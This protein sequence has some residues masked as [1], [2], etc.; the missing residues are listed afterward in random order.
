MKHLFRIVGS[1]IFFVTTGITVSGGETEID[2][3]DIGKRGE[4]LHQA[5]V[6]WDRLFDKWGGSDWGFSVQQTD[7]GGY[8]VAARAYNPSD[9]KYYAWSIKTDENG[10]NGWNRTYGGETNECWI[11]G[12]Q[13]NDGGYIVVS[14]KYTG[15]LKR[16][17]VWLLKLNSSGYLE[18]ERTYH[19]GGR[20]TGMS[21][22]QTNDNG[23]IITGT[24][25]TLASASCLLIKTNSSGIEEWHKTLNYG[26]FSMGQ[27]VRQTSDGRYIVVANYVP[28]LEDPSLNIV[29]FKTLSNG[30]EQWH[31]TFGGAG[32]D[33][34]FKVRQ[35]S[36]GGYIIVGATDSYGSGQLDVW[37]L[38]AHSDGDSL[39]AKTFGGP[40]NDLGNSIHQTDDDCDGL[41]DDGYILTGFKTPDGSSYGDLW[42]IK[43]FPNGDMD[44]DTTLGG[45]AGDVGQSVW[46]TSDWGYIATGY[47]GSY[48]SSEDVWLIKLSR[49]ARTYLVKPDGTGD[50]PTIQ[51]AINTA[52]NGDTIDLLDGTFSGSG[53]RDISFK[54]KAIT[55]RSQSGN[56][57][58]CVID[59]EGSEA[60][61]HRGFVFNSNEGAE[62]VLE[63][64]TIMN[65]YSDEGGGIFC[66]FSSPTV[67]NCYLSGNSAGTSGGMHC[68]YGSSPILTNC[69][70]VGNAADYCGGFGA[71]LA[72]SPR[73]E[74]CKIFGNSAVDAGGGIC[75]WSF[76]SPTIITSRITG[77]RASRGAGIFCSQYSGRIANSTVSGNKADSLGGAVW[78]YRCTL[79]I[80][81]TILWDNCAGE[82][83][84]EVWFND[85]GSSISFTC[86]DVDSSGIEGPGDVTWLDS[87]IFVDPVFCSPETCENAPTTVGDYHLCD[88]SPCDSLNSPN[89]CGLIGA[90]VVDCYFSGDCNGDDL[91]NIADVVYLV[92]YL[93]GDGPCPDPLEVADVNCDGDVN[94]ADVVYLVNYLFMGGPPPCCYCP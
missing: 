50:F 30:N 2:K 88:R 55:V 38:R 14:T 68:A 10:Q 74:S 23:Y 6:E 53:N 11:E 60:D 13:T 59:C 72:S 25:M 66:A 8:F 76:A 49:E 33:I 58:A 62:S 48:S 37:L 81:N 93:F 22:M 71:Y 39:W 34:A 7:D 44:W 45:T 94:I 40:N 27:S 28:S 79:N 82:A 47:T 85:T 29:L 24:K 52:C 18:W 46:Q 16:E 78:C 32:Q 77:N 36:N 26:L 9:E 1:L 3:V 17:D 4:F 70:F 15:L 20:E 84:D 87:N 56:A 73:I 89:G 42:L 41:K 61:P 31:K 51:A 90:L 63:G 21:V 35:T 80:E 92:N 12:W 83:G 75:C 54:G 43:T 65:G 19:H 69:T 67:S 91:V 57:E 5:Q 64:I 86:C